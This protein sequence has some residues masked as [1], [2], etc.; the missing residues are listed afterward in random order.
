M[1]LLS[2]QERLNRYTRE[3]GATILYGL[4]NSI[5]NNTIEISESQDVFNWELYAKIFVYDFVLEK[6]IC[7]GYCAATVNRDVLKSQLAV[8]KETSKLRTEYDAK[9]A[10]NDLPVTLSFGL[11]KSQL[12]LFLLEKQHIGEVIASV[13]N[14]DFLEYVKKNGIEIL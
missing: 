14:D 3:N 9:V 1:R 10:T 7:I 13:W 4:K 8:T 6:A 11:F 12:D 5:T 2:Y